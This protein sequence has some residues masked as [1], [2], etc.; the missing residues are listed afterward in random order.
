MR[1]LLLALLSASLLLVA[2]A[3]AQ[4]TSLSQTQASEAS[5]AASLRGM[6]TDP[7]GALVANAELLLHPVNSSTPDRAAITT[8]DGRYDIANIAPGTYTLRVT[9]PGFAVFESK[10]IRLANRPQTL[11]VQLQLEAQQFQMDVSPDSADAT[12]PNKNGDALI[13]KGRDIDQLPDDPTQLQQQLQELSGGDSPAFYVDGFSNGTLPPKNTIREIRINQNPYSARNDTDPVNGMIEI[14]TKPGTDKVHGD[15]FLVGNTSAFNT[16]N[17]YAQAQPPYYTDNIGVDFSGPIH[18]QASYA[19]N[20]GHFSAQTNAVVNAETLDVNNNQIAFAQ[21]L[22]SP[23]STTRFSPRLDF[24]LGAKSTI[25]LH[26]FVNR[27]NQTNGGVGQFNLPSQAFD[28]TATTQTL[29]ASNSQ[30]VNPKIVNDTRFQYVRTRTNQTPQSTAPTLLVEGA[31]TGGG[32]NAGAFHD[33]RDSYELQN[34][35]AIS[36]GTHYFSPGIRLRVNRD[37]NVSRSGFNGEFTFPSLAAYQTAAQALA[38][39]ALAK[40]PTQCNITGASQ[41]TLT[42]G[43]PDA[44]IDVVDL[45]V[46]YQGDWKIRKNFTL[47]YGLRY[48]L[49]NY[50]AD[51][52]DFAPRLGFAWGLDPK[53]DKPAKWVLR[54]GAGIFYARLA[55][56]N[57]LQAQ[58]QNGIA[59]QQYVVA[60]PSFYPNIPTVGSLGAQSSPTIYQIGSSFRSPYTFNNTISIEHPLG[61]HGNIYLNYIYN[62]SVHTLVTPNINSPEPGTYNPTDPASGIRPFGGTQNI[63]QYESAGLGRTNRISAN[64]NLHA[65]NGSG[66]SGYY[67][68]RFRNSDA[69]A[70]GFPSNSYN[71]AADYGRI[72]QDLRHNLA[73]AVFSPM[74]PGRLQLASFL[75]TNSGVPFNI[76]VGQDLNGDSVF[77]D[78]PA[79]ATDLTRPSVVATRFGTFDTSPVA[80]QRIIP[81]NYGQGPAQFDLGVELR[82]EFTFGPALPAPPPDPHAPAPPASAK[83]SKPYVARKFNLTLAVEAGNAPNFVNRAPPIGVL[84]SPLFGQSNALAANTADSSTAGGNANRVVNLILFTRF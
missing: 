37:A 50:I 61:T 84:G 47:S 80:G 57:I 30:I 60:S 33:N 66:L 29:Q 65:K 83:T 75:E 25:G 44:A 19:F 43:M 1:A 34:Y 49:Q 56:A 8:R 40:P 22:P 27:S 28:S 63:F 31:F 67:M 26:Y 24:Q 21:A 20:F 16:Q 58:R 32:N 77:N 54:A 38:Q 6:V 12:D 13:L 9:V 76:T 72:A 39:C 73:L 48:E 11:D 18:K 62:R 5:G 74:L 3:P 46:F 14:F 36:A 71:I 70:G 42:T 79:F 23:S 81:I 51:R 59:Q 15:L 68:L 41:F 64:V 17:P 53:K 7:S 82:R 69:S 35:L 78:R 2:S 4:S 55:S 52:G 10:P 45:A